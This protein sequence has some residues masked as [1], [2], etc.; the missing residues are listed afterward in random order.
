MGFCFC[1][2]VGITS[3][4]ELFSPILDE[5]SETGQYLLPVQRMEHKGRLVVCLDL[6]GTLVTTFTPRRAPSLPSNV[7]CYTVGKGGK[8][9]PGGIFVVERP[10]LGS[11]LKTLAQHA[12]VVLFT[13]GLE[14]YAK[15]ICDEIER[16]YG[17]V[18]HHRLY[19]DATVTSSVYPCVKDMSRLGR[20]LSKCVLVDDTPLAF[21]RQPDNGIPVL[22][23]RGDI[24]DRLLLEAVQPLLLALINI[25]DVRGSLQRRFNMQKWFL[26]QGMDPAAEMKTIKSEALTSMKRSSSLPHEDFRKYTGRQNAS[27]IMLI[28]DF[29]RSFTDWDAGERFCDEI[30]PELTSLLN[31]LESP[32]NFI[33]LTNTVLSEMF[34]RGISRDKMINVLTGMGAE[35]PKGSLDMIKFAVSKK[36]D[37]RVLSDCNTVFIHHILSG[38]KILRYFEEIITNPAQFE[39]AE[40]SHSTALVQAQTSGD[41]GQWF[42]GNLTPPDKLAPRHKLVV[43]P[44]FDYNNSGHHGCPLCPHNLCKGM[45]LE[46]M[47]ATKGSCVERIIYVGD[48]GNDYC[49]ILHLG[50]DDFALVRQGFPLE[51]LI[52]EANEV[53][54]TVMYW[55][56]HQ[57]LF[58]LVKFISTENAHS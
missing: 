34:R 58:D 40:P 9:N 55:A 29:D 26:A 36:F 56:N 8:L 20:Q 28:T 32:A 6:D 22:Q 47:K 2:C 46:R 51:R 14:D 12:E 27:N 11:F 57:E 45:E 3:Q 31:S 1:D 35:V 18:F 49:P 5:I 24:D 48:G 33:P 52:K 13:A 50:T 17:S 25:D 10:N 21:F 15:P 38:A 19:R 7:A 30:A 23:F 53:R 54:A 43:K 37:V 4:K 39:R 42:F 44:R 41:A 16:R